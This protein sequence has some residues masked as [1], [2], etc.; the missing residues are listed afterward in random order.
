MSA[1]QNRV[2][3]F[4]QIPANLFLFV[5][6]FFFVLQEEALFYPIA[7]NILSTIENSSNCCTFNIIKNSLKMWSEAVDVLNLVTKNDLT[8]LKEFQCYL[9]STRYKGKFD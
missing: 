8:I 2:R 3:I 4:F 7:A 1:D 9:N 6:F 5:V